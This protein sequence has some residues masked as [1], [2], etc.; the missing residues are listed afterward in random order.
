MLI[1]LTHVTPIKSGG[2][3]LVFMHP[4]APG[5]L[6]K[7]VNPRYIRYMY[8]QWPFMIRLQR[9][10]HYWSYLRE[11]H[12]HI[13]ARAHGLRDLHHLQNITGLVDTD[14]GLG[15]VLEA[16]TRADGQLADTL[17]ELINQG[18]FGAREQA[19]FTR[20]CDWLADAPLIVRDLAAHN[21]VWNEV[22]GH[23]VVI[24]GV[25]GRLRPSLR[26]FSSHYNR[27]SNRQKIEKLKRRVALQQARQAEQAT[28]A[29]PAA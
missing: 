28:A 10:T 26:S 5:H 25:G 24:D 13:A 6:I 1:H 17:A 2:E 27:Y 8:Q 29:L 7:I 9:L 3:K 4:H 19:A 20:F 23:F 22:S 12:E 21:L 16:V 14:L 11:L 15:M 18:R